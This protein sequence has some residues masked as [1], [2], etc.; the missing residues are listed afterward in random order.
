M[1]GQQNAGADYF[2]A[3]LCPHH[4]PTTKK[5]DWPRFANYYPKPKCA[6]VQEILHRLPTRDNGATLSHRIITQLSD[7]EQVQ[8]KTN[9]CA[10]CGQSGKIQNR[11]LIPKAQAPPRYLMVTFVHSPTGNEG[12]DTAHLPLVQ[13]EHLDLGA[14]FSDQHIPM[15]QYTLHSAVIYHSLHYTAYLHDK[16]DARNCMYINDTRCMP[17]NADIMRLVTEHSRVLIYSRDPVVDP[18]PTVPEARPKTSS[19]PDDAVNPIGIIAPI[20]PQ[21]KG[22]KTSPTDAAVNAVDISALPDHDPGPSV[23]LVPTMPVVPISTMTVTSAFQNE[24]LRIEAILNTQPLRDALLDLFGEQNCSTEYW[25]DHIHPGTVPLFSLFQRELCADQF[26]KMRDIPSTLDGTKDYMLDNYMM[27]IVHG[28]SLIAKGAKLDFDTYQ[29]QH[30]VSTFDNKSHIRVFSS[31]FAKKI[32]TEKPNQKNHVSIKRWFDKNP[33]SD[34]ESLW[35]PAHVA[36]TVV[37]TEK[38]NGIHF[39]C[40]HCLL[41][42]RQIVASD[43]LSAGEH[44]NATIKWL[45]NRMS[46]FFNFYFSSIIPW[47][48]KAALTTQVQQ[49]NNCDCALHLSSNLNALLFGIPESV[50]SVRRLRQKLPV[51]IIAVCKVFCPTK[52]FNLQVGQHPATVQPTEDISVMDL[53]PKVTPPRIS[54][55]NFFSCHLTEPVLT[56]S[57]PSTPK[58]KSKTTATGTSNEKENASLSA[59]EQT[60]LATIKRNDALLEAVGLGTEPIQHKPS[61]PAP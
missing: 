18:T 16:M 7:I 8:C 1:P 42:S 15:A 50:S 37:S 49:A 56:L 45:S 38:G 29:I 27:D 2:L 19:A 10:F 31:D 41:G 34:T 13:Y 53:D 47:K 52:K 60:R 58:K 48:I 12:A 61:R 44:Y 24:V 33:I 39:V 32:M 30:E 20:V 57:A 14:L 40:A 35:F 4:G 36:S 17:I 51:F 5:V 25:A 28:I 26:R 43:S 22:T 21:N 9:L 55:S 6:P 23:D 59:Y 46:A 11:R 3:D 54:R